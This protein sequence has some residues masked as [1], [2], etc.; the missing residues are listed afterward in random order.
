MSY[1]HNFVAT[2]TTN[3]AWAVWK[4]NGKGR[5]VNISGPP[6]EYGDQEERYVEDIGAWYAELDTDT[7]VE[8]ER[9]RG[10]EEDPVE[11]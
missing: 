3:S 9:D 7:R 5:P 4:E 2:S 1:K 6:V 11:G 10:E 8:M